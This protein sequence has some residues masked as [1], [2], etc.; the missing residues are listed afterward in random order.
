MD[1]EY[2]TPKIEVEELEK[3][4]I[5]FGSVEHFSS[6]VAPPDDWGDDPIIDEDDDIIW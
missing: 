6:Y 5:L 3:T 4:D 2:K 1:K